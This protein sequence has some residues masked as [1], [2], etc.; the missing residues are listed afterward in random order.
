MNFEETIMNTSQNIWNCIEELQFKLQAN[1]NLIA[2]RIDDV[3]K[4]LSSVIF[5]FIFM[6]EGVR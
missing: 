2:A 5:S 6:C 3:R 4:L 1:D